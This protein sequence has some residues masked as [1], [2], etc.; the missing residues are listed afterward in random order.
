MVDPEDL[1]RKLV[2]GNSAAVRGQADTVGDAMK[3]VNESSVR[4]EEAADRPKWTSAA[5]AGY[6]VRTAGVSQGIEVNYFVLGRIQTALSTGASEYDS[7]AGDA[8]VAIG[9]WRD[10]PAGLNPVVE[11]LLALGVH[12]KLVGVSAQYNARLRAVASFASGETIDLDELDAETKKWLAAGMDKTAEW[13]KKH[14]NGLGPLIPNLGLS[15]DKRGLIPQGLGI[16]P[17]TGWIIQ[18]SY[19]KDGDQNSVLSMI[20]PVTGQEMTETE[21][22]GYQGEDSEGDEVNI[23]TPDHAGGVSSHGDYTYVTSSGNPSY[24]LKYLTSDLKDGGKKTADPVGE[25]TRLPDGAG[26]YATIKDGELYVGTHQGTIG[27]GG[28]EY[29][30]DDDDGKLYHYTSDGNGGWNAD[31]DFGGGAGYVH[32]PPQAQG[33]VVRD[34]EYVFSASLGRDK[35]GRLITQDRQDDESGNG[36]RGPIH[37]LPYMSEG[38][39]ELNGEIIATY[40]SGADHYGPDGS[41]DDELWMNPF[42]TRTSLAEL[43]L[44]EDVDVSPETLRGAATDLDTAARPLTGAANL[45]GGI[46]VTAGNFGQVAAATTLTT[47]LNQQLGTSERSLDVGAKAVHRTSATLS[48]NASIYTGTDEGAADLIGRPGRP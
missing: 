42:M 25:P 12:L 5:S 43:G 6:R 28:G 14:G 46:T 45:V 13:L 38:I 20:D 39:I 34:G 48:G 2:S 36:E 19:S 15:G 33:V 27:S 32:T 18:T 1:Y 31:P 29:D 40:E 41:D 10:R 7:M 9:Y 4:V 23:P 21:L 24:L 47:A 8:D 30:G 11:D 37:E 35:T 16:D 17:D 22:G 44:S 3:K 26:A